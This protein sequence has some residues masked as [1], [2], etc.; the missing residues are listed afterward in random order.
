MI[1]SRICRP[2]LHTVAAAIVLLLGAPTYADIPGVIAMELK[3]NP[4]GSRSPKYRDGDK[5]PLPPTLGC[6]DSAETAQFT[7]LLK[8]GTSFSVDAR[9]WMTGTAAASC[10]LGVETLS[11]DDVGTAGFFFAGD[12][13]AN[14]LLVNAEGVLR[15]T[16]TTGGAVANCSARNYSVIDPPVVDAAKPTVPMGQACSPGAT[17]G[18]YECAWDPSMDPGP[19]ASGILNY[20]FLIDGNVVATVTGRSGLSPTFTE[21]VIGGVDGTSLASASGVDV[22]LSFG[23]TGFD[24]AADNFLFWATPVAGDHFVSANVTA[25]ASAADFEKCGLKTS[26]GETQAAANVAIYYQGNGRVQMKARAAAGATPVTVA[27]QTATLPLRLKIP[28]NGSEF[29]GQYSSDGGPWQTLGT[30]TIP[31]AETVLT[32]AFVTS[33]AAGVDAT[34]SIDNLAVSNAPRLSLVQAASIPQNVSTRARDGANNVSEYGAT[35]LGTPSAAPVGDTTPPTQTAAGTGT[36]LGSTQCQFTCGSWSDN[37]GLRGFVFSGFPTSS[38]GTYTAQ[39][40][41]AGGTFVAD[42]LSPSTEYFGKCHGVDTSGNA[43]TD[44]AAMSCTTDAS[45]PSF[46]APTIQGVQALSQSALRIPHTAVAGADHYVCQRSTTPGGAKS[47]VP[48]LDH[49]GLSVDD[50]AL[51]SGA[52]RCYQCAAANSDESTI[53]PM[54]SEACGTTQSAPSQ[55]AL[56]WAPGHYLRF[57]P[58]EQIGNIL[59]GIDADYTTSNLAGWVIPRYWSELEPTQGNYNIGPSSPVGQAVARAA[60]RGKKIIIRVQDK[61]F[62]TTSISGVIPS[63]LQSSGCSY[64]RTTPQLTAGAALWRTGCMTRAIALFQALAA[65]YGSNATVVALSAQESVYGP[66]VGADYSAAAVVT[67]EIRRMQAVRDAEPRLSYLWMTN[68]INGETGAKTYMLQWMSACRGR[69]GC[70]ITGGP[71][72]LVNGSGSSG[73]SDSWNAQVGSIGPVDHRAQYPIWSNTDID[74]W[75]RGATFSTIWA[76]M[77]TTGKTNMM[78]WLRAPT[79]GPTTAEIRAF[80]AANAIPAAQQACP[81]QVTQGCNTQ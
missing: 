6:D 37:V 78:T 58:G 30:V 70:L 38:G 21:H 71:D 2:A 54:S 72:A 61:K 55:T 1:D 17:V 10:T 29:V 16:C 77:S 75:N 22:D 80:I 42:S 4:D 59:S 41:Q 68:W 33:N 20:D 35:V 73:T 19:N 44:S 23:G 5:P 57:A 74:D 14:P 36:A 12:N 53:G 18:T 60:L 79:G 43:G 45:T 66:N 56:R 51:P 47:I 32:G 3:V 11:G 39:T 25:C 13:L 48:A 52:Q 76:K 26:D 49:A 9:A 65:Q 46:T 67:E 28:R 40:E 63:Y 7:G 50:T 62:G 27:T 69:P 34:G 24:A 64:S 8:G 15:V 81:S 31:M